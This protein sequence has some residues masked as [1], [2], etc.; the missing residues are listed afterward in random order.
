MKQYGKATEAAQAWPS[1]SPIRGSG[2]CQHGLAREQS[3]RQRPGPAGAGGSFG[4]TLKEAV[5]EVDNLS[6]DARYKVSSLM[7][8]NGAEVHLMP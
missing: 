4:D 8:G 5:A 7:E 6:L 1:T 3:L 2:L